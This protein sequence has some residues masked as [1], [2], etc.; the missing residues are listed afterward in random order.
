MQGGDMLIFRS[1]DAHR[2]QPVLR[3]R[4]HILVLE[5]W[6]GP[7]TSPDATVG[8]PTELLGGRETL[9][10]LVWITG[11]GVLILLL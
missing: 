8:R 11:P 4:R 6:L 5:F 1:W 3:G 2:S 7:H 9:C 10:P